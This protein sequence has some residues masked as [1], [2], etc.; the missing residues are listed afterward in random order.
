MKD[1]PPA[2]R[3]KKALFLSPEVYEQLR[4]AAEKVVVPDQKDFIVT[5]RGKETHFRLRPGFPTAAGGGKNLQL[6]F[7]IYI[8]SE[9]PPGGTEPQVFIGARDGTL[10]LE[11]IA[12]VKEFAPAAGTW[13]L[14]A[15]IEINTTTGA[16]VT[17]TVEFVE[18]LGVNTA[19]IT[20]LTL[21]KIIVATGGVP[22]P[23]SILQFNYGPILV[24]KCGGVTT[25]WNVILY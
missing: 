25:R 8:G 6:P 2:P 17:R 5:R 1:L 20:H 18:T 16:T 4:K 15:K 24:V 23:A 3:D 7:E 14:Q 13:W 19:A 21:G 22:D 9:I 12:D 10:E 11:P